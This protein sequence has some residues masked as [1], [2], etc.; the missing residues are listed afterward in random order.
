MIDLLQQNKVFLVE[1][2]IILNQPLEV[3]NTLNMC[4][5]LVHAQGGYT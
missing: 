3:K 1:Y 2:T 5:E 4:V